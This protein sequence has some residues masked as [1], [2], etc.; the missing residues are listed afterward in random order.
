MTIHKFLKWDL[1]NNK[2]QHNEKQPLNFDLIIIDEMSMVDTILF[3]HLLLANINLHKLVLVGDPH[4][5]PSINSGNVLL[6]LI[7]DN[8]LNIIT[9]KQVYRQKE[10]SEIINLA[11]QVK[12]QNT[13]YEFK[14]N[15]EVFFVEEYNSEDLLLNITNLFINLV[16]KSNILDV[17]ILAS[18]YNGCCGIISINE[19]IQEIYNPF[20][21]DKPEFKSNN[22]L[23]RLGDKVMQNKN[24][25]EKDI[26]NG[27]MGIIKEIVKKDNKV[28]I[29]VQYDNRLISYEQNELNNLI[30]GY[31]ISV[32]KSQG[33]EYPFIIMVL[34]RSN[35][36]MLKNNLIYTAITRAQKQ[37]YLLGQK[38]QFYQAIKKIDSL[39]LTTLN[40]RIKNF[41]T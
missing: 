10:K 19:K 1:H 38:T 17:Q 11:Y 6:D 35:S 12:Q 9:L 20:S 24:D 15:N 16:E 36:Y 40:L 37:L 39:R 27:D 21:E 3:N 34:D 29:R 30:L 41:I 13:N 25:S 28:V 18:M 5:L 4:Q 32:H 8:W 23:F 7:K 26:Y 14:E 22:I 33:S 2:F 31:T